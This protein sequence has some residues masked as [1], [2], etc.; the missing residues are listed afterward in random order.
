MEI[1]MKEEL[2][3][4][5]IEM[6]LSSNDSF[7]DKKSF[8]PYEIGANYFIRTVTHYYTGRLVAVYDQ[9]L[10]LED[11]CWVADTGRFT[12][13]MIDFDKLNEV[14]PFPRGHVLVGRGAVCD[15]HITK[16]EL[17]EIQK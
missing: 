9:E 13:S 12:D 11:V 6:A 3:L 2:I 10:V 4:K 8:S 16:Q 7:S 15:A 17:P 5:L 1:E 14:E